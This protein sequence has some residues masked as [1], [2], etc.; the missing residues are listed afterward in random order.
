[1]TDKFDPKGT[2]FDHET[3][4]KAGLKR[5]FDPESGEMHFQSR[6]PLTPEE[7]RRWGFG[8]DQE[9]G[10]ILKGKKHPTFKKAI[11]ADRALGFVQ[12]EKKGRVF[13]LRPKRP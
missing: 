5:L 4:I 1:M 9:V 3:A 2:G 12:V 13:T 10:L 6:L 11:D 7:A 8:P